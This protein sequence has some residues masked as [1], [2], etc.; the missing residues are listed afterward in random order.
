MTKVTMLYFGLVCLLIAN[1]ILVTFKLLQMSDLDYCTSPF[2]I[3]FPF[4]NLIGIL[5]MFLFS[6]SINFSQIKSYNKNKNRLSFDQKI[7]KM[8]SRVKAISFF[9]ILSLFIAAIEATYYV[10][11][12]IIKQKNLNFD[13][14][15]P[16]QV[17]MYEN[18]KKRKY[19]DDFL[20]LGYTMVFYF[21]W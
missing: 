14:I 17:F 13:M 11:A 5:F 12:R 4:V 19:L 3:S 20:N 16:C 1:F 9:L 8:K 10:N 18:S 6:R 7:K 2:K 15:D 21:S